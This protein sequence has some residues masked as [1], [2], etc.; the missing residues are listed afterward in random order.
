VEDAA[1]ELGTHFF[2]LLQGGGELF[3]LSVEV[4]FGHLRTYLGEAGAF[5]YFPTAPL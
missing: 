1:I 4:F 3:E 5:C 2:R